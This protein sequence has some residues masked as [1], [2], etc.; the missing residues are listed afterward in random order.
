MVRG[1]DGEGRKEI[2]KNKKM[3]V[4]KK[5]KEKCMDG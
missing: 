1:E 5:E 4:E 2:E 3:E